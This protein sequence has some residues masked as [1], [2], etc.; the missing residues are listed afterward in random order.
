[1]SSTTANSSTTESSSVCFRPACCMDHI[2]C[3]PDKIPLA[4]AVARIAV[5]NPNT[6]R[7][8]TCTG[9]LVNNEAA[10]G[11]AFLLTAF[12]CVDFNRN[13]ILEANE[14][15]A[16]L[17]AIFQF[18]VWRTSCGGNVTNRGITFFGGNLRAANRAT[19]MVL[20]ELIDQPGV[21]DEVSYAGWNRQTASPSNSQSFIIH[22][23]H[24]FD[25]RYTQTSLVWTFFLNDNYWQAYYSNGAVARGSSGSAL[26]NENNQIVGQLKGGASGC[27]TQEYSDR[28]GKFDRSWTGGGTN[29]TG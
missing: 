4:R 24:G 2:Q 26:F 8:G 22:H 20:F 12:H 3:H 19:D 10:N 16:Y 15:N 9:T 13:N 5:Q 23:P 28:Y 25:M 11:R 6:G 17:G 27:V 7:W 14:I 1:M 29:N 21:G 18:F